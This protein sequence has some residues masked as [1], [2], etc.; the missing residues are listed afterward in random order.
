MPNPPSVAVALKR[1]VASVEAALQLSASLHWLAIE[2]YTTQAEHFDRWGYSKLA[3]AARAD[4]KEE[5]GHLKAVL[6][7]LEYYDVQPTCDHGHPSWPRHDYE[8]IL[9]ANLA[10]ESAAAEAERGNILVARDSGDE[11]SALVFAD[12]LAGSEQS[13]KEIEATQRVIEQIGL[14]NYLANKV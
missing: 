14:D 7:R 5:R 12:L 1:S 9:D 6:A 8:G 11:L 10:L 3:E 2:T 4:A 13:I